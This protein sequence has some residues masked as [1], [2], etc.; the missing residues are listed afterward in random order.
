MLKEPL[1]ILCAHYD[2]VD[3]Y[4]ADDNASGVTAVLEAARILSEYQFNY[5]I[6]YALWDEEESG[7]HGSYYYATMADS[8]DLDIQ[9]VLNLEMF[10]WDEDGDGLIDIHTNDIA[11]SV[12]LANIAELWLIRSIL[13]L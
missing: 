11:N 12:S 3:F 10:G 5:T 2:A 6:V 1:F 4:C 13:Y 8:N 7:K 9:G